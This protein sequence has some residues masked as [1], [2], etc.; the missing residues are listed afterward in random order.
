MPPDNGDIAPELERRLP[1]PFIEDSA[2]PPIPIFLE[3]LPLPSIP[4]LLIATPDE[5]EL[6][7]R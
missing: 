2:P 7:R 5:D 6:E 3:D 1:L 4:L